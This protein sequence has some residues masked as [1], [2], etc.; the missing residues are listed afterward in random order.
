M[1][2]PDLSALTWSKGSSTSMGMFCMHACGAAQPTTQ[3]LAHHV[4]LVVKCGWHG[5]IQGARL[6]IAVGL[7]IH[8]APDC[9]VVVGVGAVACD[10][11]EAGSIGAAAATAGGITSL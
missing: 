3:R 9:V 2:R 4:V 6:S 7:V 10:G 8:D 11:H 1:M 5:A